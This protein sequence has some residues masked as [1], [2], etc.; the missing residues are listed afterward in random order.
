MRLFHA[1]VVLP[2]AAEGLSETGTNAGCVTRGSGAQRSGRAVGGVRPVRRVRRILLATSARGW[3]RGAWSSPFF[4]PSS[5]PFFFFS[6]ELLVGQMLRRLDPDSNCR[7][8]PSAIVGVNRP[9]LSFRAERVSGRAKPRNLARDTLDPFSPARGLLGPGF[10]TSATGRWPSLEMTFG[11]LC[12]ALFARVPTTHRN[13]GRPS[14]SIRCRP[15]FVGPSGSML[16]GV[17]G[18]RLEA[19][20][21]PAI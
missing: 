17:A 9:L 4:H 8:A 16:D 10:S 3:R 11:C 2:T 21:F 5:L 19:R 13:L 18:S 6:S 1:P 14:F 12:R 20:G 15:E 7:A